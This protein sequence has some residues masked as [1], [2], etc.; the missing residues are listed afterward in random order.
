MARAAMRFGGGDGD[1][2]GSRRK[3]GRLDLERRRSIRELGSSRKCDTPPADSQP[4]HRFLAPP[5]RTSSQGAMLMSRTVTKAE[6]GA[7]GG[8]ADTVKEE[9]ETGSVDP[10]SWEDEKSPRPPMEMV[11]GEFRLNRTVSRD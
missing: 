8:G 1:P 4:H 3:P 7:D 6:F 9:V 11:E 2:V 5:S 10:L